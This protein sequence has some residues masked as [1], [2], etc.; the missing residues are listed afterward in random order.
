[1]VVGEEEVPANG[2]A[3]QAVRLQWAFRSDLL[4]PWLRVPTHTDPSSMGQPI[5]PFGSFVRFDVYA[6][7]EIIVLLLVR[8]TSST[9]DFGESG[10]ASGGFELVGGAPEADGQLV[11]VP[12][13]GKRVPARQWTTL[14]FDMVNDA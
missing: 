8:N 13:N 10:T 1:M 4:D 9:G 11:T 2:E 7:Q 3:R 12:P 5:I 14:Y 6:N